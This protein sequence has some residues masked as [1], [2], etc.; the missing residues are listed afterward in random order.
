MNQLRGK[1]IDRFFRHNLADH[2]HS[3]NEEHWFALEKRLAKERQ[4]RLPGLLITIGAAAMIMFALSLFL[5]TSVPM[6]DSLQK[7]LAKKTVPVS[8]K[9]AVSRLP[10]K[11]A[12]ESQKRTPE[13][14]S[15]QPERK[16]VISSDFRLASEAAETSREVL[17][18]AQESDMHLLSNSTPVISLEPATILAS[19][20]VVGLSL[21]NGQKDKPEP[22]NSDV[23]PRFRPSFSF[24]VYAGP[25]INGVNNLKNID[26]GISGGITLSY[27]F[28][29]KW[30]VSAGA[31]YA[32]K[33]YNT[34]FSNYKPRSNYKFPVNP[35]GVDADCRLLD[36]PLN[37]N[38][39]AW[40]KKGQE[41][42]L[43][44]GLSSYFMLSE[45]YHFKYDNAAVQ[46]PK[47]Y[48]VKNKN[49]HYL[50][51]VNLGVEYQKS[52]SKNLK[53]GISP[54]V[55]LPVTDIGYGNVRLQS[56][57]ITTSVNIQLPSLKSAKP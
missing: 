51:V 34:G 17:K 49:K 56:A 2:E 14:A 25:D 11:K 13:M 20:P 29:P 30:S 26:G 10:E 53:I 45:D 55:K 57:G 23:K 32:K 18:K 22:E 47:Y 31:A 33:L 15:V 52:V 9:P 16:K 3:F 46:S 7:A 8:S 19:R 4:R 5:V 41:L 36:V 54:Y 39:T 40:S 48:E 35:S 50:G 38:Y 21:A 44:A 1:E 12:T 42:R 27:A 37:I 28:K 6:K 24:S 43:S